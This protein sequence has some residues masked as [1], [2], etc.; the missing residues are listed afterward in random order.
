MCKIIVFYSFI[1]VKY[2]NLNPTIYTTL[3]RI[4]SFICL[5]MGER[6]RDSVCSHASR[7]GAEEKEEENLK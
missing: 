6:E 1:V 3:L 2:S 5:I 7:R 4:F